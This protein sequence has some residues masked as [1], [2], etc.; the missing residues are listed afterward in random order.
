MP[1]E[2]QDNKGRGKIEMLH[3]VI[4][5][6][7]AECKKHNNDPMYETISNYIVQKCEANSQTLEKM[8]KAIDEKKNIAG[9][10][11]KMRDLAKKR[12]VGGCGVLTPEEGYSI[13]DNYFGIKGEETTNAKIVSLTDLL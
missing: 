2:G 13:V 6:L 9:A 12:S 5:A 8:K 7:E 10:I 4:N 11:G 3:D 1:H